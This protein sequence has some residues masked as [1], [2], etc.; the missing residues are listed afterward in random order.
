[1]T[2]EI[3]AQIKVIKTEIAGEIRYHVQLSWDGQ[4]T[5]YGGVFDPGTRELCR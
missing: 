2:S 3:Y 5:R 4:P 1:M